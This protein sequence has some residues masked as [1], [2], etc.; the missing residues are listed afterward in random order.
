MSQKLTVAE[1]DND[2]DLKKEDTE[3]KILKKATNLT[4]KLS[5]INK[6][7]RSFNFAN[8]KILEFRKEIENKYPGLFGGDINVIYVHIDLDAFY[9]SVEELYFPGINKVPIGIG[10]NFMLATANYEARKFGVKSGMPGYQAKILCPHLKIIKCN[11]KRYNHHSQ[12]V[13]NI[14]IKFDKEIE[15]YGVDEAYLS[16]TAEKFSKAISRLKEFGLFE[17]EKKFNFEGVEYLVENIRKS[18]FMSTKLS[19]SAGI[20]VCRGLAKLSTSVN[21]PKGQFCLKKDFNDFI[22][23]KSVDKLN[24]IG[25]KTKKMLKKSLNISTVKDLQENLEKLFLILPFKTFTCFYR[26]SFGL[27]NFDFRPKVNEDVKSIGASH[28]FL[29]TYDYKFLLTELWFL[30]CRIY[31]RM[32][33]FEGLV[34]TLSVKYEN[35]ENFSKQKKLKNFIKEKEEIFNE[36]YSLLLESFPDLMDAYFDVKIRL[37][38][39]KVSDLSVV[40]KKNIKSFL[41]ESV[42]INEARNCL[43]CNKSFLYE[44]SFVFESHV[45]FCLNDQERK[46][47]LEEKNKKK[48]LMKF[49]VK[50]EK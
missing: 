1:Q 3:L 27:S 36:G 37:L 42:T 17:E 39:L 2:F 24:G 40:R 48:N 30:A 15:I 33:K 47:K 14:L 46:K 9:A 25:S 20:S 43:I 34:V 18:V 31:E 7:Q 16:F 8:R 11:M 19:A 49:L 12:E 22:K 13:M 23:E 35:F 21:K 6:N 29:P 5:E 41:K 10:T 28:S 44:N 26:F 4:K 50:R 45:N 38:A 32:G